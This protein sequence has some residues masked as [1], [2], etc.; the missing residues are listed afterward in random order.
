[1]DIVWHLWE[2]TSIPAVRSEARDTPPASAN[3]VMR[4]AAR[5]CRPAPRRGVEAE[6]AQ[7]VLRWLSRPG[8]PGRP[9]VPGEVGD[10]IRRMSSA[11]PVAPNYSVHAL[12]AKLCDM[13]LHSRMRP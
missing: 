5:A 6:T 2:K 4:L 7:P 3:W 10:L 13:S 11:N 9:A 1:V 8:K 12:A